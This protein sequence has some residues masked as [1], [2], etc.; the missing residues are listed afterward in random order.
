MNAI[1]I[2]QK[3]TLHRYE[4]IIDFL[5]K[6]TNIPNVILGGSSSSKILLLLLAQPLPMYIR[7]LGM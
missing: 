3:Q 7:L 2:S 4:Y 1:T 6:N 5:I